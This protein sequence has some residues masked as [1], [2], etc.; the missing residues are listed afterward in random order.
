[1]GTEKI[2]IAVICAFIAFH[3]FLIALVRPFSINFSKNLL[4]NL[5]KISKDLEM[6]WKSEELQKEVQNIANYRYWEGGMMHFNCNFWVLATLIGVTYTL[7]KFEPIVNFNLIYFGLIII[8]LVLTFIVII[9]QW[10]YVS[11]RFSFLILTIVLFYVAPSLLFTLKHYL[12]IVTPAD[13]SIIYWVWSL[14]VLYFIIW[15][16]FSAIFPP[17]SSLEELMKRVKYPLDEG[18]NK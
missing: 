16:I 17:L 15:H 13:L 4:E 11:S 8:Y 7:Q 1:M 6:S 14:S 2:E 10:N 12:Q 5:Y 18:K 9:L 3:A